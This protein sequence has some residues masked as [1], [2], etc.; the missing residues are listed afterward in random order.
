MSYEIV[1]SRLPGAGGR[2][3]EIVADGRVAHGGWCMIP[4]A[5]D[6]EIV[7]ASGCD[8]LCIDLQHGLVGEEAMRGMVQACAIRGTPVLVRVPWNEP[9]AIMRALDAGAEGVIVPMVNTAEEAQQAATAAKYPPVGNRSWGP[10][11]SGMAQPDFTPALGNEQSVC[12]VM[13]ETVEAVENLEAILDVPGVD[14]V[15]VG[16]NDLAISHSGANDGAGTSQGDVEM[17][18][19]IVEECRRRGLVPGISCTSGENARRWEREGY[20]LLALPSDAALI[21]QGMVAELER[22]RGK[23]G[24]AEQA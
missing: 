22:A 17:I 2:L 23:P 8:W 16:P 13:I 21:A 12:L 7:S 4:S 6:A 20:S 1:G 9:G 14:G 24:E 19:R 10:L 18:V 15:F 11:R 3:R 5:F